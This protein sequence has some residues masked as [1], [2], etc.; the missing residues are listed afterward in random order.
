M[1]CSD[2]WALSHVFQSQWVCVCATLIQSSVSQT[3]KQSDWSELGRVTWDKENIRRVILA[4]QTAA[5]LPGPSHELCYT[6]CHAWEDRS[7][8]GDGLTLR[9][10]LGHTAITCYRKGTG[11]QSSRSLSKES[12]SWREYW[13]RLIDARLFLHSKNSEVIQVLADCYWNC[14]YYLLYIAVRPRMISYSLHFFVLQLPLSPSLPPQ[15]IYSPFLLS[16]TRS[17]GFNPF[18]EGLVR[19]R[20]SQ[21]HTDRLQGGEEEAKIDNILYYIF[22]S[23]HLI[24]DLYYISWSRTLFCLCYFPFPLISRLFT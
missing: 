7:S 17:S 19:T 16:S 23:V 15:H 18:K 2:L 9:F 3:T 10:T 8:G 21:L 5:L 14:V 11:R 4:N 20:E 24:P 1:S 13:Q 22:H 6:D 12:A